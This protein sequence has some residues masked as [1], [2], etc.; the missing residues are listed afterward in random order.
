MSGYLF[1]ETFAGSVSDFV[2]KIRSRIHT[3]LIPFLFWNI[4]TLLVLAIA[5]VLPVTASFFSGRNALI[6]SF[7]AWDY[8]CALFGIGRMPISYQS[9]QSPATLRALLRPLKGGRRGESHFLR[10]ASAP[11]DARICGPRRCRH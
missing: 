5:Q 11:S 1:F 6:E 7:D 10:I 2:R 8:F 4:L 9:W 3:L